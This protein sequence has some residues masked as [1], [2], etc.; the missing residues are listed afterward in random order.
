MDTEQ[1]S[2]VEYYRVTNAHTLCDRNSNISQRKQILRERKEG[3]G[4]HWGQGRGEA[5]EAETTIYD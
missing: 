2:T 3:H 5:G 4:S 1:F